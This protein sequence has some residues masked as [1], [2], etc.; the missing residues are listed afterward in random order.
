MKGLPRGL[1]AS[2][3]TIE[4]PVEGVPR[5]LEGGCIYHRVVATRS[6]QICY[7]GGRCL[8]LDLTASLH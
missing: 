4:C 8:T 3:A 7:V 1:L 2:F 6:K 5:E